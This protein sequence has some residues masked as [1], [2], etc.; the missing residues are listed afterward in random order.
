MKSNYAFMFSNLANSSRFYNWHGWINFKCKR[1]GM[2]LKREIQML[3][4][5]SITFNND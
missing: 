2:E 1:Y 5:K 3:A 4:Y